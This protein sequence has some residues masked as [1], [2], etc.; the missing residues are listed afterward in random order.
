[1]ALA[2]VFRIAD[3][4]YLVLAVSS[5]KIRRFTKKLRFDGETSCLGFSDSYGE[6]CS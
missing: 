5:V 6:V 1:M 2:Q 4:L 3:T